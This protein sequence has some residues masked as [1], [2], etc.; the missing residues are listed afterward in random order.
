M[1]ILLLACVALGTA[2]AFPLVNRTVSGVYCPGQNDFIS[3]GQVQWGEG[4]WRM[5]GGGRVSSKTSFNLLGGFIEFDMDTSGAHGGV[6]TNL[7]T[8]SPA[9]GLF[10]NYCDIQ[11]NDSPQC[12]EMDIIEM[13]GNCLGQSTWH[14]WP[15]KNGGCDENGC[16][17]QTRV[18]GQFHIR[19]DFSSDGW[20][21]VSI[22]GNKVNYNPGPSNNAK[23]YV[24]KTMQ[25]V[26]AQIQSSQWV[27]WVPGADQCPGGS[28]LYGSSFAIKNLRVSGTVVQG[29]QPSEC[30]WSQPEE[31]ALA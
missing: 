23:A 2:S 3:S 4:G 15:N 20:M 27:G 8:T 7:Y 6:N 29:Q 18:S 28:Q 11:P 31:A 9:P 14:T 16:A 1:R 17:G 30:R 13:N 26:G 21:T 24:A 22:N 12:M 25:E 5:T 19:T 10:P